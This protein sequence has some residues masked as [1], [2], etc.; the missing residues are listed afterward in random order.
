M[1]GV[2]LHVLGEKLQLKE[3]HNLIYLLRKAQ[4]YINYEENF[5]AELNG[6]LRKR[7]VVTKNKVNTSPVGGFDTYTP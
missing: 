1:V 2:G 7:V 3:A 4:P 6:H 5:L